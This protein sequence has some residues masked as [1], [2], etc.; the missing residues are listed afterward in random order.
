MGEKR[1]VV[2]ASRNRDKIRE[3]QQVF[4]GMPFELCAAS[5]YPGLPEVIEDGTTILGNATRKA[6]VTAAYTGE[7]ALADDTSLQVRELNGWPDIFASRFSG[8]GATYESNARRL[9]EIMADVPDGS[10]QARFATACVW[11]DPRPGQRARTVNA[12]ARRRWLRNPWLRAV[13]VRDA[14]G[15]RAYWNGLQDRRHVWDEYATAMLTDLADWGH[16]RQLLRETALSLLAT[17]PDAPQAAA[18]ASE[19]EGVRV[20][21]PRIWA[22][23]G[24]DTDEPPVTLASPAGLDREAPGRAVNGPFFLE[25]SATGKL[26]GTIT[27]QSV[28]RGGFGYDP[29]F[30]PEG[31]QRTLAEMPPE[32]K[33]VVSHRG[34][35]LR[36]LMR[37]V[38]QAYTPARD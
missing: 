21:D 1:K 16:D 9:L 15:E 28:G 12:P 27:R 38:R 6:L 4:A 37:A 35:A 17:C 18:G 30:R 29:V 32:D 7:I 34:R 5:D 31:G 13:D 19:G 3:L 24:P 2:L 25:L 36:R 14:A 33:N 23:S 10:R 11:I 22:V 26:V 8:E 20:P